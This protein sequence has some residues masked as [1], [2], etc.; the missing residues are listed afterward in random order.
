MLLDSRT[1]SHSF[2]NLRTYEWEIINTR[3]YSKIRVFLRMYFI[4]SALLVSRPQMVTDVD[5]PVSVQGSVR[6]A[7]LRARRSSSNPG[8]RSGNKPARSSLFPPNFQDIIRIINHVFQR[9]LRI[10]VRQ[11]IRTYLLLRG[12]SFHSRI[13]GR[14]HPKSLIRVFLKYANPATLIVQFMSLQ[15][16]C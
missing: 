13:Y 8:L 3:K 9:I 15:H 16:R 1:D 4:R 12:T 14:I 10:L 6:F 2:A 11:I 5:T 7:A